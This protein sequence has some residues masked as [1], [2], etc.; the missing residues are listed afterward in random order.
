MVRKLDGS[1]G[2]NVVNPSNTKRLQLYLTNAAQKQYE[3]FQTATVS[4]VENERERERESDVE[5]NSKAKN[6]LR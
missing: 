5:I 1:T 2:A 6:K 4:H 3:T